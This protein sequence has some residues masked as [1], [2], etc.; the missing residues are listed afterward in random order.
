MKK[1]VILTVTLSLALLTACGNRTAA[2]AAPAAGTWPDR[3][4]EATP[5]VRLR[6]EAERPAEAGSEESFSELRQKLY[7]EEGYFSFK[8]WE[9]QMFQELP[10]DEPFDFVVHTVQ[11]LQGGGGQEEHI[12]VAEAFAAQ[13]CR[14]AVR[15]MRAVEDGKERVAWVTTVTTTP[16]HLWELCRSMDPEALFGSETLFVEQLYESVALRFDTPVWP[17]Q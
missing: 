16:A 15:Q 2:P 17:E 8:S 4:P 12:Q 7:E 9:K 3:D 11:F 6:D 5:Y 10:Q 14:A 1:T 13:G